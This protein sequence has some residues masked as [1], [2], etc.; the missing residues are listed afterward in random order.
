MDPDQN[1]LFLINIYPVQPHHLPHADNLE[2]R[3]ASLDRQNPNHEHQSPV[4]H[5]L[6]H[7]LL[8]RDRHSVFLIGRQFSHEFCCH[9][10]IINLILPSSFDGISSLQL[11]S[12]SSWWWWQDKGTSSRLRGTTNTVS[13]REGATI[14]SSS[15]SSSFFSSSSYLSVSSSSL[16]NWSP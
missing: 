12:L 3:V 10:P 13:K 4:H 2:V 15:N 9:F 1:N 14:I 7:L 8:V 6:L 5:Q 16:S 11:P